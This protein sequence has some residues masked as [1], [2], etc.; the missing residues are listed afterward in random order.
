MT[1]KWGQS[2]KFIV[3]YYWTDCF[4][5][6][7]SNIHHFFDYNCSPLRLQ[8]L[9]SYALLWCTFV[10]S[11]NHLSVF[12]FRFRFRTVTDTSGALRIIN[13]VGHVI[14][15]F[16]PLLWT[17]GVLPPT[18]ALLF[19]LMEQVNVFIFGGSPMA[20]NLRYSW[21]GCVF[22]LLG[23]FFSIWLI[24][25]LKWICLTNVYDQSSSGKK[26]QF[27]STLKAYPE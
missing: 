7:S 1:Q 15:V 27:L 8:V 26:A 6:A 24:S 19:W 14:F 3:L 4:K 10:D 9:F 22:V 20:S 13:Q 18:E 21:H 11:V 25:L 23:S 16:L 2:S 12:M 17:S 5:P